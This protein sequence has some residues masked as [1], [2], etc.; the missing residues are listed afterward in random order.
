[1]PSSSVSKSIYAD[2]PRFKVA[3]SPECSIVI[4]PESCPNTA[5]LVSNLIEK[6]AVSPGN[7][8]LFVRFVLILLFVI[9]IAVTEISLLPLFEIVKSVDNVGPE[10]DGPKS[11]FG[12]SESN[13]AVIFL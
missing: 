1:M 10:S 13:V 5:P 9:D 4:V 12:L 3:L 8:V 7:I 6:V 11:A 2:N